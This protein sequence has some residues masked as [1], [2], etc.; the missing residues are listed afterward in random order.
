MKYSKKVKKIFTNKSSYSI[1]I[2]KNKVNKI[3]EIEFTSKIVT[4]KYIKSL[5]I[6][7]LKV[8]VLR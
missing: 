6:L 2:E 4:K 3:Y 1:G 7:G 5:N 8:I